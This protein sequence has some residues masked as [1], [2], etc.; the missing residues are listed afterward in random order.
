[1]YYIRD[2]LA[3]CGFHHIGQRADFE[4]H[5]FRVQLQCAS[6]Y[7]SWLAECVDVM[8]AP[9]ADGAPIAKDLFNSTQDWLA[10]HW[11][12]RAKILISCAAG[13]SRSVT[14]AIALIARKAGPD[15]LEAARE[16]I[17][18][19]PG[20]YPHP[21]VLVSASAFCGQPLRLQELQELYAGVP[22][23]PR[24]P[25]SPELLQEAAAQAFVPL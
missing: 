4:S 20:A 14:M 10:G 25:W 9:F 24:Y 7:D 17:R 11:D 21:H 1:M 15:F 23:Q 13:H 18:V 16:V 6:P 8:A 2:N 3:V 22:D 12:S 5:G 19:V